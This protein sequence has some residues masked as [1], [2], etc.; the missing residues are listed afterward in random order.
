[1]NDIESCLEY[2]AAQQCSRQWNAFLLALS[3]EFQG[4]IEEAEL[5]ALMRR[6][7]G[8]MAKTLVLTPG[9]SLQE[10]ESS[11]NGIWFGM[12]WGWVRLK[13]M[14]NYL[15]IEHFASPLRK[16]FGESALSWTPALLEGVYA[17]WLSVLGADSS[18]RLRQFGAPG[19]I[20]QPLEF[21]FGKGV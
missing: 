21:R 8:E 1:M 4:K 19:G 11:I 20:G 3:S 12:D 15:C 10:L 2:H 6:I 17:H 7:G 5:R 18:L 16:S 14:Q 13:E 9:D